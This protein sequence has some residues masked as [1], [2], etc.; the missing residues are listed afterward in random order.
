MIIWSCLTHI[1]AIK[2]NTL[3]ILALLTIVD[4]F[5]DWKCY[6][7]TKKKFLTFHFTENHQCKSKL[8]VYHSCN[9]IF[10]LI[11]TMENTKLP[12]SLKAMFKRFGFQQCNLGPFSFGCWKLYT[13]WHRVLENHLNKF[14]SILFDQIV[15]LKHAEHYNSNALLGCN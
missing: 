10:S 13:I 15:Y 7:M 1:Q 8:L 14:Y 4:Y 12:F 3:P 6:Q 2:Y 9:L 5:W 11:F